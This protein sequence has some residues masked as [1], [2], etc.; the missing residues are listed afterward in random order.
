MGA[1][2]RVSG[3]P[4]PPRLAEWLLAIRTA[5]EF[6]EF[7]LGDLAQEYGERCAARGRLVAATWFWWQALRTLVRSNGAPA[8]PPQQHEG[9]HSRGGLLDA[10]GRDALLALRSFARSPLAT[11]TAIVTLALGIG[12]ATAA[13]SLADAVLLRPIP[14][15]EAP[16]DVAE[17]WA[18]RAGRTPTSCRMSGL[19]YANLNDVASRL[20]TASGL[21]GEVGAGNEEVVVGDGSPVTLNPQYVTASWFEVLGMQPHLGRTFTREEAD[22]SGA[23]PVAVISHRLWTTLFDRSADVLGQEMLIGGKRFTVVGVGARGFGGTSRAGDDLW[24]P[25]GTMLWVSGLQGDMGDRGTNRD[26]NYMVVRRKPG[27]SWEQV[28]A[29]LDSFSDWLAEQYPEA[30]AKFREVDFRVYPDVG[31][32]PGQAV[33]IVSALLAVVGLILLIACANVSTLLLI[34]GMR[35]QGE[36]A[37]RKALGASTARLIGQHLTENITLWFVGG[38]AGTALALL[39]IRLVDRSIP[40]LAGTMILDARIL[41]FTGALSLLVGLAFGALPAFAAARVE[42][43]RW[44]AQGTPGITGG[45]GRLR[46]LLTVVQLGATLT[47]LV[48]AMLMNRT[49]GELASI[50]LGFEAR[51]VT[52]FEAGPGRVRYDDAGRAEYYRDMLRRLRSD[53]GVEGAAMALMAPFLSTGIS[54]SVRPAGESARAEPVLVAHVGPR[55]FEVLQ[56]P[57]RA[58][59]AFT[60]EE[61]LGTVSSHAVI[62]GASTARRLFGD[63]DP[64]GE[65]VTFEH[66]GASGP[67]RRVVGIVDDVRFSPSSLKTDVEALVYQPFAEAGGSIPG[68]ATFLVRA[69]YG[70]DDVGRLI[71][72]TAASLDEDA[73]VTGLR[74]YEGAVT[75]FYGGS[76]LIASLS[77]GMALLAAMLAAVGLYG[78]VGVAADAR[79]REFGIRVA[80]GAAPRTLLAA[81]VREAASVVFAGMLLGAVGSFALGIVIESFLYGVGPLDPLSWTLAATLLGIVATLAI[82]GPARRAMSLDPV[83]VLRAG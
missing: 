77:S 62:L 7:A 5:S 30:N 81:V 33:A 74:P 71:R 15:I 19:S 23:A 4:R 22:P 53:P 13:F 14:G 20:Q 25:G 50:D 54:V 27:T 17:V 1:T 10:V 64:L 51:G 79:T 80:L 68:E 60:D 9:R 37:V 47:L 26:F 46:G 52:V 55:F 59:R 40:D 16:E 32:V 45:R 24:L 42:A 82:V 8:P 78:V 11:A 66:E 72:A 49:L 28:E 75:R 69:G 56:I 34:K 63:A 57:Q 58:G 36:V 73:R 2:H 21:G 6:R 29:E 44:L 70:N 38:G 31:E 18:C 65:L 41:V 35:R 76:P 83:E 67:R 12:A 48:A 3:H 39:A 43:A 61:A